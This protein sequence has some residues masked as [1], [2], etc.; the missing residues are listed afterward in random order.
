M[1]KKWQNISLIILICVGL[2]L[3][4][5]LVFRGEFETEIDRMDN[6]LDRYLKNVT[7]AGLRG[8]LG[9]MDSRPAQANS[10]I[11][12]VG[13]S[14]GNLPPDTATG[15]TPRIIGWVN[16]VVNQVKPAVVGICVG[17]T[18]QSPPWQ[19]GWEVITPS[20]R[21]SVGSG[22]I[23]HPQGYVL[24]NYHVVASGGN[25]MISLFDEKGYRDY[26]AE[27]I[28]G[29]RK[30]DLALLK[31]VGPAGQSQGFPSVPIG[32]SGKVSVGD[33]VIAIGNPFGLTQ[34]VTSGI[35]SGRRRRLPIGKITLYDVFQTDVP[36]SPG[37]SGGPLLNLRGEVIGINTA[38][39]SPVESLY[40]GISF[41]I[42]INQAKKLFG[43]FLD[44]TT[45]AGMPPA[46]S[47]VGYPLVK[48]NQANYRYVQAVAQRKSPLQNKIQPSPGEGI[49]ELAWL[50]IDIIPENDA[51]TTTS[52]V[53]VDEVEGITPMEAGLQAGDII[54][55]VNGYPT[56][57]IYRF[58]EAIKEVPLKK[59]QGVVLDVYRPRNGQSLYIDFRLQKWDLQ[60][61]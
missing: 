7:P 53:A 24:T 61:R 23:I 4:S 39:F 60:G 31:I 15:A 43:N 44:L 30:E 54:R 29:E 49:E 47:P 12:P 20:G 5:I 36:I 57:N 28:G 11:R 34:T 51:D 25:I 14:W 45:K 38:I 3:C 22:I 1:M 59:G 10:Y 13:V 18:T 55:S 33:K 46:I 9:K 35:I 56:P 2:I 58:K 6:D 17:N 40:T 50:G 26:P 21:R 8:A 48:Q 41:A 52:Q 19:Q 27:L 37:N 42:P 32:D 16:N